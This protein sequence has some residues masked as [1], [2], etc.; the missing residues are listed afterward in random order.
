MLSVANQIVPKPLR[1]NVIGQIEP[2]AGIIPQ[3]MGFND[4]NKFVKQV[5]GQIRYT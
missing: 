5:S 3:S 4:I 1:M 2:L